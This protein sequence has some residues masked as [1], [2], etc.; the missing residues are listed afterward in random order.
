MGIEP[1]V[2]NTVTGLRKAKPATQAQAG[3]PG[4]GDAITPKP[5]T[6]L[7]FSTTECARP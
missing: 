7:I 4:S 3:L 6:T 1:I 5:E 2:A